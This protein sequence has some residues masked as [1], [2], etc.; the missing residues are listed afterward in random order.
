MWLPCVELSSLGSHMKV[1]GASALVSP[2][3]GATDRSGY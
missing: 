2:V 3:E 1:P